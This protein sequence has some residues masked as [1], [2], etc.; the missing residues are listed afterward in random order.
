EGVIHGGPVPEEAEGQR[1]QPGVVVPH[2]L[3]EGRRIAGL[4][5][6]EDGAADV[7][8]GRGR[9]GGA[10][11]GG[12]RGQ[13]PVFR[14]FTPGWTHGVAGS[15]REISPGAMPCRTGRAWLTFAGG[16]SW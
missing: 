6:G 15:F 16:R 7:A 11:V 13:R 2:E 10:A 1:P 9:V 4:R 5:P 12:D 8:G 14:S 3:G